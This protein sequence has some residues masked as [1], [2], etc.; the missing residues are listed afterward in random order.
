[1]MKS[2]FGWTTSPGRTCEQPAVRANTFSTAVM[3][4]SEFVLNMPL[5]IRFACRRDAARR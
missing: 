1:M 2:G 4:M 3:P 5:K